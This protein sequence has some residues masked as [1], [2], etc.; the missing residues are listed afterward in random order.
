M[1]KLSVVIPTLN[2]KAVLERT[3]PALL[4]QNIPRKDFEIIVVIDGSTDGTDEL[5]RTWSSKGLLRVFETTKSMSGA[6]AARNIGI[7]AAAGEFVL[8]LDDDFLAPPDLLR[9]HCAAHADFEPIVAFGPIYVAPGSSRTIMRYVTEQRDEEWYRNLDPALKLRFPEAIPSTITITV[10]SFLVNASVPREILLRVGG[11]DEKFLAGEDRELGL[12]LWKMGVQFR[13]WP[14][15][16]AFEYYVKSAQQHLKIQAREMDADLRMSRKHPEHRPYS[17]LSGLADTGAV[18]KQIRKALARSPVSPIP[19]LAFPLRAEK[20]LCRF[21]PLRRAGA[22]LI[23][24]AERIARLRAALVDVGSWEALESEFGLRLPA[25]MYHH[26]GPHRSNTRHFLTVSPECFERQIRW[27][28]RKGYSGV[29]PSDWLRWRREGKGLNGKPILI[30]FDDAY[31]DTA[32]FALP[33]LRRYGFGGAVFVVTGQL[34]GTNTW[35]EAEGCGTLQLMTAEQ[36]QYWAG[37]GIEFGAHTRTHPHLPELSAAE[38]AAEVV[39]SKNDLSALL[40]SPVVSFAYP[41]GEYNQAIHDLVQQEFDLAFSAEEGLNY[42]HGDPH[43]LRR[44]YVGPE[45]S[46]MEFALSVR[47]GSLKRIREWRARFKVRSR[48]RRAMKFLFHPAINLNIGR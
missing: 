2:R 8:F 38:S 25:L 36:I 34:G 23:A 48:L 5:L 43:L 37:K 32:E 39:G 11:F 47:W 6:G 29:T 16:V 22:R 10:L 30:S 31:E 13:Y 19:L 1:I 9:Q 17:V 21:A 40:G 27:L 44:T 33:I 4:A 7:R 14:A 26:V 12:R 3:I 20:L 15:A 41:Y 24:V 18:K 42:L 35:D 28:A 45:D 46:L